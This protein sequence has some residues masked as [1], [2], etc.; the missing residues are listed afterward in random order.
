VSGDAPDA[1]VG[2]GRLAPRL[3]RG[4]CPTCYGR[5]RASGA[6]A[7]YERVTRPADELLDEWQRLRAEG[8]TAVNA[9]RRIGVTPAA[10][11]KALER[12]RRRGDPRAV[13]TFEG[14]R[15]ARAEGRRT[16]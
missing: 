15:R 5:R 12:A 14:A 6:L 2:C 7:Y 3:A 11:L 9:A 8:Y 16:R 4:L 1:C 10:L 13:F